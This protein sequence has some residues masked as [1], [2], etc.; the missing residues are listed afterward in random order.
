[1]QRVA[2]IRAQLDDLASPPQQPFAQVLADARAQAPAP[3]DVDGIVAQA[4]IRYGVDPDL[5]HA[6]IRAESD[7]DPECVSGAGAVGLMQLMPGT[8]EGLGVTDRYDPAQNVDGGTRYL[9]QQLDSFGDLRLALAAY[10]AGPSH[11][12]RWVLG[13]GSPFPETRAY[14]ERV[15]RAVPIYRIYFRAPWLLTI[16]PCVLL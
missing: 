4:A 8:A 7:Y 11:A 9:R 12:E 1:M 5:I 3:G 2:S 13:I 15:A 6:V 10:N 16:T 14:V